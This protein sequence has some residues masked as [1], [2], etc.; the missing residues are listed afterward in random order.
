MEGPGEGKVT[1]A[2]R[3]WGVGSD[4]FGR[5]SGAREIRPGGTYLAAVGGARLE[6]RA[7]DS[8]PGPG[9]GA[10][11]GFVAHLSTC[12]AVWQFKFQS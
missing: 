1:G 7:T 6:V 4:D 5:R 9:A 10:R 2:A 12:V 8:G 3:L 11:A